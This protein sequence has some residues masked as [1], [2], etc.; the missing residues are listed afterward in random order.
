MSQLSKS[1]STITN[2]QTSFYLSSLQQSSYNSLTNSRQKE[3]I[4]QQKQ[5]PINIQKNSLFNLKPKILSNPNMHSDMRASE[6]DKQIHFQTDQLIQRQVIMESKQ[7][8]QEQ[9]INNFQPIIE[10]KNDKFIKIGI[11]IIIV[12]LL[13]LG[14]LK[15]N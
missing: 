2:T 5:I 7:K 4:F 12:L 3:R 14:I 9:N 11:V 15:F 13:L 10:K 1:V 6:F 8:I